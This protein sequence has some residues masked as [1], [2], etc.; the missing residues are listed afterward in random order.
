MIKI[1]KILNDCA[2]WMYNKTK[3]E[4]QTP[5]QHC[6]GLKLLKSNFVPQG[7]CIMSTLDVEELDKSVLNREIIEKLTRNK[8]I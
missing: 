4:I 2:I 7:Q 3:E 8:I 1:K 6:Y 5:E